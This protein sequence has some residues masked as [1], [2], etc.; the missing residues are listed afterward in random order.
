MTR[1]LITGAAGFVGRN[2][3]RH[4]LATTDW[5]IVGLDRLDEAAT[6][7]A[8]VPFFEQHPD[9]FRPVWHNL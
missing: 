8:Y 3:V 4:L 7:N 2:L 9:R 6:M 5:F 1:V